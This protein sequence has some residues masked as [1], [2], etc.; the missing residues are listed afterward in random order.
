MDTTKAELT[1]YLVQ[2]DLEFIRGLISTMADYPRQSGINKLDCIAKKLVDL[3]HA[4]EE[5]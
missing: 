4:L 3:A 5:D 2:K 1:I